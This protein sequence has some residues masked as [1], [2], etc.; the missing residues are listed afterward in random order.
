MRPVPR[1]TII[2]MIPARMG[3]QRLARK[4]LRELAG[5]PLITR[6]IRKC[7]DAGVFDE[8]WVNSEHSAFRQI[9]HD[10]GVHFHH[11]PGQLGNDSATSEQYI[12]EFLEER[13]CDFLVQVH[14]IAPLLSAEDVRR[15]VVALRDGAADSL[16]SAELIQLECAYRDQPINF[17]LSEKTNSQDLEP[18]QRVSWSITGWRR[19]TYLDAVKAGRCGTYAG[20]VGFF[21]VSRLAGYVIKTEEDLQI[22]EA[23][24][25]LTVAAQ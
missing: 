17:R 23:L 25:P 14:S 16:L 4:N 9:A 5:I 21:P 15:F 12:T 6:A 20:R 3:S 2:G 7:R 1:P 11:R 13:A 22:V 8:V 24:L 10:E 18:V 19:S